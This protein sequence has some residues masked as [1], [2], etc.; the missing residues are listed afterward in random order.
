MINQ[1]KKIV[2]VK[3]QTGKVLFLEDFLSRRQYSDLATSTLQVT[4][5]YIDNSQI[6]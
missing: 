4:M 3:F 2:F 6:L 1:I 5:R